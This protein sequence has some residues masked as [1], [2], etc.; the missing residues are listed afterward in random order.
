M[1]HSDT[2]AV[3]Q[4]DARARANE[5]STKALAYRAACVSSPL[6]PMLPARVHAI[7]GRRKRACVAGTARAMCAKARTSPVRPNVSMKMPRP[8]SARQD[9][10]C[11]LTV[12]RQLQ[13]C[14]IST[15]LEQLP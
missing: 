3:T 2:E 5:G 6:R 11:A 14:Y 15:D 8:S 1:R 4:V 10:G 9:V 12:L 7:L 13:R